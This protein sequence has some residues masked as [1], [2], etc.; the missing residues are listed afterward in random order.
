MTQDAAQHAPELG[1]GLVGLGIIGNQ[2]VNRLESPDIPAGLRSVYD[3]NPDLV[4]AFAER[5]GATASRS[6][7]EL[8]AEADVEAIIVAVPS[9]LHCDIA[10]R[11]LEAGKHVLLEKPIDITVA[12]ADRILAAQAAS[13]SVL[14]VASQRRFAPAHRHL[15]QLIES[16]ALGRLTAATVEVP[17]WRT[18]EYYDSA[19]WRGTW[20]M[21]GGGALMNQGVHLVDLALWLL[22]DVEEVYAHTGLLAHERIEVE[23]TVS[24]TARTTSGV[25]FTMLVTTAAHTPPPIRVSIMGDRGTVVTVAEEIT[26]YA[27]ATGDQ[28][29][30]LEALQCSDPDL[31]GSNLQQHEQLR[32][33]VEAVRNGHDPLVTGAQARSAVAFIEAVY[34]SSRTGRPVRPAAPAH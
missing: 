21:D 26:H 33:F 28:V 8:L 7:D 18:Q 27:T 3:A 15:K 17:L 12:A 1:F 19:G 22:G 29:P 5:T 23:D 34:E 31:T 4:A 14:S 2:H 11:A 32:D 25:Q 10:V 9:G 24:A 20:E 30:P 13:G 16:G 6:L